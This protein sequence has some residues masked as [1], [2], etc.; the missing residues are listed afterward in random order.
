MVSA[1]VK[2]RQEDQEFEASYIARPSQE[3]G[4]L[5]SECGVCLAPFGLV[6]FSTCAPAPNEE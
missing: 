4:N 6:Y 1:L 3:E 5:D 2:L